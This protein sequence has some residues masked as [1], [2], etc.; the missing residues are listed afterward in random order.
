MART[1]ALYCRISDDAGGDGLGVERQRQDCVRFAEGRGWTVGH[2]YTD[3]DVSAFSGKRRPQYVQMLDDV[4]AGTVDAIVAWHPDR[5]HRSPREL[6]DFIDL[7]ETTGTTVATVTAGD[8]DLNTGDG[9]FM[10]RVQGIVARKESEDKSRRLKRKH[11]ELAENGQVGGG[12]RRPFGYEADRKTVRRDEAAVIR[13]AAKRILAGDSIRS[14]VMDWQER[15]VTSVTGAHWSST[16]VKRLLMSGRISGRREHLGKITAT[17]EW[18]GIITVEQS[19]ALRA[20]LSDPARNRAAGMVARSYLLSG[21]VVCGRTGCSARLTAGAAIQ[22]DRSYRIARYRCSVDRGGCNRCGIAAEPLEQL[23]V[24]A[25]MYRLDSPAVAKA[26]QHQAAGS[27]DDDDLRERVAADERSLEELARDFY[28]AK[29][30]TRGEFLAARKGLDERL[31]SARGELAS[32][33]RR[34]AA[35]EFVGHPRKL[36]NRWE[37]MSL[38]RRR[39]VLGALIDRIVIAPTTK[40]NNRFDADRVDVVWRV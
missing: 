35:D 8:Y 18:K 23:I 9:R 26:M 33:T 21:F 17:A 30:I 6:E 16:T 19:D 39:A 2:V 3:N 36:R 25:V 27:G 11:L 1:A 28:T 20:I 38:E 34:T 40:G 22:R 24:D 37:S 15:G 13:E 10:A 5:L 7:I 12:G 29:V 4:K 14:V 32:R 31:R